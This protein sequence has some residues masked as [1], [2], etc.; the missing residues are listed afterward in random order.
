MAFVYKF[1]DYNDNVIYI[2]KTGN[3]HRRMRDHFNGNGHLPIECYNDVARIFFIEVDGKTNTDMY[4]TYLINKYLPKYN[5]E[6]V[7]N[8]HLDW[9]NNKF[10]KVYETCWQ[11]LYFGFNKNGIFISTNKIKTPYFN[12]NKSQRENVFELL[13]FNYYQLKH[14][15]GLYEHYLHHIL[16]ENDDFLI[17]LIDFTKN[18]IDTNNICSDLSY[19]DEPIHEENDSFQYATI[20]ITKLENPNLSYLMLMVQC[21]MLVRIDKIHYGIVAHT[22]YALQ[23]FDQNYIINDFEN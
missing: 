15:V 2:G 6:K 12:R 20:D 17:Y 5:T 4:E 11:E 13:W 1:I 10:I 9:H 16:K 21:S 23:K 3:L 8:E 7:F 22:P 18:I 14:K 19:L